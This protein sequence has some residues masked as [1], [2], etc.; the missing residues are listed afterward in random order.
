MITDANKNAKPWKALVVS[1]ALDAYQGPLLEGPLS[2]EIIEYRI[3][4]QSHTGKRGLNKKGRETPYPTTAPDCL[5]IA[6]AIE[7]SLSGVIYRDDSQIVRETI[8][9]TWG[10]KEHTFVAI[11]EVRNGSFPGRT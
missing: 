6:R 1:A 10:D 11:Q 2:M 7:D 8:R 9:K 3:R 5:K 4:P